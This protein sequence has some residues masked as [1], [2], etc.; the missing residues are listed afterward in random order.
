LVLLAALSILVMILDHQGQHLQKIRSALSVLA[1]PIP[2]VAAL[3][4]RVGGAVAN[5]FSSDQELQQ[6]LE[7]LREERLQLLARLQR[8]EVLEAE[9]NRLRSM[10]GSAARVAERVLAADLLGVSLEPF[11]R[12]IV[13][14][15]GTN[16]EVYVGQ[17]VIDAHGVMGQITQ[18][19]SYIS[20]ATLIT[21]P[22][23][24]IPVMVNRNGL[25]TIVFGT[26]DQDSVSVPYLT[27]ASDIREGDLLI[28]SGMGGIFPPGYPVGVV[29]RIANDPN[30]AFLEI[31][32]KPAA[33]INH[34]KQVLL[35]WAD[36][37]A[38]GHDT[39]KKRRP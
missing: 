3:P 20:Y 24:A 14:A 4:A 5:F 10:L 28:S 26:G 13:V 7:T 1:S 22:G 29:T 34:S 18:V 12:K 16:D 35:I 23:H 36:Q 31:T 19:S 9:N 25:R 15:R 2:F 8:L 33:Q 37:A 32:A 27:S 6:D 39:A 11:T 17:P 30:E 38:A 21:D